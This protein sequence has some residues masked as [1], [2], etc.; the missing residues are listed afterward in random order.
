MI[1]V[2]NLFNIIP[3]KQAL[4]ER[5]LREVQEL[6][7]RYQSRI[8]FYGKTRIVC[9]GDYT[10]EYFGLVVYPDMAALKALSSDPE[11]KRIRVWRDESTSDFEMAVLDELDLDGGLLGP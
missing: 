5:Y 1:G 4:Y 8:L 3:D 11:F 9:L 10:Q 7:P 6:L 2:L